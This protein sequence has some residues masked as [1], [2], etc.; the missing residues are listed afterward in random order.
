MS[1]S[2]RG[3]PGSTTTVGPD[4]VPRRHHH[5]RCGAGG[6]DHGRALGHQRLLAVGGAHGFEVEVAPALHQRPEDV[7]DP[8]LEGLVEGQRT[9]R[10]AGHD[11][12]RE[13]V[14]R[15]AQA[16]A[17]H[18]QVHPL[19][20]HERQLG[21]HV[22]GPVAADRDVSELDPELQQAVGQPRAVAVPD[23]PGEHLGA[24]DDDAG[25]GAHAQGLGPSVISL[26]PP[27]VMRSPSGSGL[28]VTLT[29]LPLALITPPAPAEVHPQLPRIA[30]GARLLQRALEELV[31]ALTGVQA[32]VGGAIRRD[33]HRYARRRRPRLL[34]RER[35]GPARASPSRLRAASGAVAAA[36]VVPPVRPSTSRKTTTAASRPRITARRPGGPGETGGRRRGARRRGPGAIG[37]RSGGSSGSCWVRYSST[38]RWGSTPTT[39]A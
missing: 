34:L 20:L 13:V 36:V 32:G 14:R 38:S 3:G 29:R 6:L 27:R 16:A 18:D 10:E 8:L 5:P 22:L 25:A 17:G 11:L 12:E 2:S 39:S 21:L 15:R 19:G 35:S 7:R 26:A 30:E 28:G 31:G 1:W 4:A 9:A 33:P 37:W 24:R 23:S